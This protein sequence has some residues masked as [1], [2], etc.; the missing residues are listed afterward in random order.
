MN[1]II[2]ASPA[3]RTALQNAKRVATLPIDVLI[4]GETGTGKEEFARF[5]HTNSRPN[6][7]FVAVNC[8]SLRGELMESQ[9]FGHERGS[10][11]GAVAAYKGLWREADGGTLFLDEIGELPLELQARL[12]RVLETGIVQPLGSTKEIRTNVRV[13]A[14]THQP[15]SRWVEEGRFRRDLFARLAEYELVLPPLRERGEDILLICDFLLQ[16]RA[17]LRA[18][19]IN[20][21]PE[22]RQAMLKYP[23]PENVRG[24]ERWLNRLVVE[25]IT[26]PGIEL[27]P[28]VRSQSEPPPLVLDFQTVLAVLHRLGSAS[29]AELEREL[30]VPARSLQYLLP[31]MLSEGLVRKQ[32]A[33]HRLVY[34]PTI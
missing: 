29:R 1:K 24:I 12:L 17:I 13:I 18:A 9:L 25:G 33:T 10:F 28:G 16:N 34:T 31:R 20:L 8:A 3:L 23:W 5:I 11:S 2:G 6:K 15:I 30:N 7:P 21:T 14:A 22:V 27:V 26:Q 4:L 32:G 19:Q